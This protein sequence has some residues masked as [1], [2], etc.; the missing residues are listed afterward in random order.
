MNLGLEGKKALVLAASDGLGLATADSLAAEGASVAICS[1]NPERLDVA[2]RRIRESARTE[3][4]GFVADVRQEA[5]LERLFARAVRDLRGLDILV[6]NAGGPPSGSFKELPPAEWDAAYELTL[7]SVAR[8]VR[9]ALPHFQRSGGGCVLAIVSS[10]VRRPI[11]NLLLSNV[12]RPAV[13]ALCK[14]LSVELAVDNIRVNCLAPGRIDTARLRELDAANAA[15]QGVPLE[16]IRSQVLRGIPLGRLGR[17]EEFGRVAA[18]LCSPAA[19]YI[20]GVTLLVDGG[21]V[22]CL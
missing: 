10:S 20:T 22:T 13:Q 3:A 12:F 16:E 7:L 4:V 18:F 21:M 17:P 6:C 11:P 15:R 19:A 8:S 1:R 5:D 14:S 9:F 2:L